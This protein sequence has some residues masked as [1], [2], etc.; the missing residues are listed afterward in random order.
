[1]PGDKSW[2]DVT[3]SIKT[4][5]I[6]LEMSSTPSQSNDASTANAPFFRNL[7]LF[8]AELDVE[9]EEEDLKRIQCETNEKFVAARICNEKICQEWEDQKLREEKQEM[10][11][12][13][14]TGGRKRR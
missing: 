5:S 11:E 1:M 9:E 4:T 3:G 6:L 8:Q 7:E 12:E 10:K 2:A 13:K 14:K